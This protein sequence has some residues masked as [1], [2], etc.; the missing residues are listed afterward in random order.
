MISGFQE[1]TLTARSSAILRPTSRITDQISPQLQ[2]YEP[3]PNGESALESNSRDCPVLPMFCQGPLNW[4]SSEV[5]SYPTSTVTSQNSL[6]FQD[7]DLGLET[8]AEKIP[9][10]NSGD[11]LTSRQKLMKAISSVKLRHCSRQKSHKM[12][13]HELET[14][15]GSGQEP[16]SGD[17][18]ADPQRPL[19]TLFSAKLQRISRQKNQAQSYLPY[20]DGECSPE[21]R[22]G[23][24]PAHFRRLLK[25]LSSAKLRSTSRQKN[26]QGQ[27]SGEGA[28]EANYEGRPSLLQ[29]LLRTL[30]SVVLR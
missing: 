28:S 19:K 26:P 24:R 25:T 30:F 15:G 16:K 8:C 22:S 7:V 3:S 14:C 10:P 6:Q 23:D 21:T 20:T 11:R 29:R 17:R 12:Q 13:G 9:G 27:G 18:P 2:D 5:P 1:R 4:S